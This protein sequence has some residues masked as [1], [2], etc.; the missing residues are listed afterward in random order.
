MVHGKFVGHCS[1]SLDYVK[2][3]LQEKSY[4]VRKKILA[5][6]GFKTEGFNVL[7]CFIFFNETF[8]RNSPNYTNN[9]IAN[10]Y[11]KRI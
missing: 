11:F 9:R 8:S 7:F 5:E 4:F 2:P 6:L 3:K 10:Y 1:S